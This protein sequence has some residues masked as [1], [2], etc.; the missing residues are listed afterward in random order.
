[1]SEFGDV[2]DYQLVKWVLVEGL[3]AIYYMYRMSEKRYICE[4]VFT[5]WPVICSSE[6]CTVFKEE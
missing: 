3:L 1:M 4:C 6:L 2:V 5:I